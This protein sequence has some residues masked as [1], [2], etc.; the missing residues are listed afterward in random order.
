MAR[1]ARIE[2][3]GGPEVIGWADVE[4]P[5]PGPG[6][7]RMRNTV[8]GLNFIDT[9]FRSGLY[10]VPLPSGL[11]QEAAGVIEAVGEGVTGFAPGDRVATF[12][13]PIGAYATERNLPASSLFKLP[14]T[15]DDETAA[16]ALLKGCTAEFLI[17]RCARVQPGWPVLVHAA[18]GGVGQILVQ[19]LKAIGAEVIGTV[20]SE[21]KVA[22][23]RGAGADHVLLSRSDDIAARVR[24]ITGGA[25]VAVVFDGVGKATWEA[26]LA[27]TRRRGLIVSYGNASG[28]VEGVQLRTL[29]S[30]GSLFV[31]R[32]TSFDYYVT[33]EER[34][35]GAGRLFA[36]LESKAVRVGIGQRFALED[37]A[38][39]HRALEAGET[40]GSTV[41]LP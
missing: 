12:G 3:T 16:A 15:V 22:A 20:G 36:M 10:P 21:A 33:P 19:W 35:A 8:I 27:A 11:G 26:S 18:A 40:I 39:A 41:L 24:E 34:A 17:E 1:V 25:G 6:E 29:A 32:P 23:A 9:Y 7:V 30:H 13:P 38:A 31:S 4:L 2:T 28:A 14:D 5:S 37:V